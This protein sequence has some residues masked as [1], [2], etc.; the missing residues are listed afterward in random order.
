MIRF[1]FTIIL[2]S[3]GDLLSSNSNAPED[4]LAK[5]YQGMKVYD[6]NIPSNSVEIGTVGGPRRR[7]IYVKRKTS[8]E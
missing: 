8:K 7:S 4:L 5:R 3:L 6:L 2:F 1:K